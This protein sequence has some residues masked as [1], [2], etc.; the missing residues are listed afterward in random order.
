MNPDV[1]IYF[2]N[3]QKPWGKLFYQQVWGQLPPWQGKRLLDFGSGFGITANHLGT[4]NQVTAVEPNQ[5]LLE[6][7]VGRGAYRQLVGSV[8]CLAPLESQSF[9]GIV[10]HNV[11][12]YAPQREEILREFGRLLKPGGALSIVKHNHAGRVLSKA[13]LEDCP[14]EAADLLEGGG[15]RV[16]NF[17]AVA[18]YQTEDLLRWAPGL[19]L[20]QVWGVRAFFGLSQNSACKEDPQWQR[21]MLRLEQ[22]AASQDPY[23]QVAFF[24]HALLEKIP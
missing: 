18:Y 16:R 2:E 13:V 21:E 6:L 19:K 1:K 12:E 14:G 7:A 23:R 17:G 9:D 20:R 5:E 10:C 8:E 3:T 11:L 24:H 4:E 15:L 22:L